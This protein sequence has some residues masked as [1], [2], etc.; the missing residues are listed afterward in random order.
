MDDTFVDDGYI[1]K[2]VNY[3]DGHVN[4]VKYRV[5]IYKVEWEEVD[6]EGAKHKDVYSEDTTNIFFK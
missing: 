5:V 6:E 3:I 4:D 2:Q 1:E